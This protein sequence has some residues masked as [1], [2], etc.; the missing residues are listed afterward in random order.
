MVRLSVVVPTYN[1]AANIVRF[2][3][4]LEAELQGLDYEVVTVDDNSPDGTHAKIVYHKDGVSTHC[5]RAA[6][7]NDE[8]PENHYGTW[9][10]VDLVGWNGYPAGIRDKLSGA[11]FGKANFGLKDANFNNLLQKAKPS[12]IP[13]DPNA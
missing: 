10:Y 4:G 3:E 7:S 13:F 6:N 5:F 2:L 8:P 1:E 11:D 9:Q 12:G